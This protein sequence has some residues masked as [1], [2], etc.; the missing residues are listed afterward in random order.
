M[1]NNCG[2][3]G[4]LPKDKVERGDGVK[5]KIEQLAKGKFEYQLPP[6]LLSTEQI[7]I[8]A[9][10]GKPYYG[11]FTVSNKKKRRMK[12]VIYSDQILFEI[13]KELFVGEENEIRY[14]F[15]AEHLKV[16]ETLEGRLCIVTDAGEIWLP[17]KADVIQPCLHTSSKEVC[18]L[19]EFTSLAKDNWQEAEELFFGQQFADTLFYQDKTF[20]PLYRTLAATK[21]RGQALEQF[22]VAAG[23]KAPFDVMLETTEFQY[24]AMNYQFMDK[25]VFKKSGW[26]YA[27]YELS[28]DAEFLRLERKELTSSDF[29]DGYAYVGF[30]VQPIGLKPGV[31]YAHIK[32]SSFRGTM[33]AAVCCRV[34]HRLPEQWERRGRLR[35]AESYLTKNYLLFRS[36]QRD[37]KQYFAEA[38]RQLTV[39]RQEETAP[40][41]KLLA[42]LYQIHVWQASGR[43]LAAKNA[44]FYFDEPE[45][46]KL[47]EECPEAEGGLCYLYTLQKNP[48]VPYQE[49]VEKIRELYQ[50]HSDRWLLLWYLLYIDKKY[51]EK[52]TRLTVIRE[53]AAQERC[54]PVLMFEAL[55]AVREEPP[56]L[57]TLDS[58]SLQLLCFAVKYHY[59][60][61]GLLRQIIY[62]SMREKKMSPLLYHVLAGCYEQW[63]DKELLEVLCTLII[64]G[65]EKSTMY[66]RW[67]KLGV[68]EQIR[69]TE[70]PEYYMYCMDESSTEEIDPGIYMYFSH[71]SGLSNRKKALLYANLVRH[72][73]DSP[74]LYRK[75]QKEMEEFAAERM[76]AAEINTN[77][78]VIYNDIF[79]SGMP[80]NEG[81]RYLPQIAFTWRVSCEIECMTGVYVYHP[82]LLD[83]VTVPLV[84]G[85]SYVTLCTE[86]AEVFLIDSKGAYYPVRNFDGSS[87]RAG[88]ASYTGGKRLVKMEKLTDLDRCLWESY[89]AGGEDLS[90]LLC[91]A[92][93]TVRSHKHEEK[94]QELF[95][96]IAEQKEISH[97]LKKFYV[98]E[99]M[100][101]YYENYESELF[102]YY[103]GQVSLDELDVSRRVKVANLL[104][105]RG[106]DKQAFEAVV[107]F[108]VDG[109]DAKRLSKLVE[110]LLPEQKKKGKDRC[111]LW[112]AQYV[113]DC[114]K[115]EDNILEY[116]CKFYHG[117]T[118]NMYSVWKAAR[119]AELD[120]ESLEESLLGQILFAENCIENTQAVFSSYCRYGTNRKLIRAYLCYY[121]YKYLTNDWL[122]PV[123][124]FDAMES[125]LSVEDD[126]IC[127]IALL[128]HYSEETNLTERQEGFIAHKLQ[129]FIKRGL[130]LPFFRNFERLVKLPE[131]MYDKYFVEYHADPE[132]K[133]KIHYLIGEKENFQEAEMINAFLGIFVYGFV[134]F[135]DESLQYY[136]TEQS[137]SGEKLTQSK[138][139][140]LEDRFPDGHGSRYDNLNLV[141]TVHQMKE[142]TA[143]LDLLG[144]YI[145]MEYEAKH[146]F[147]IILD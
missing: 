14:I 106:F 147:R 86:G 44:L 125:E 84:N 87:E 85:S 139:V 69:I 37:A 1:C 113:F 108:G 70:L 64:R 59:I 4:W 2:M 134:L 56:L 49:A 95:Q 83:G 107:R 54:C 146:L 93:Q 16:G 57:R 121:A 99:L 115:Y 62:L 132:S 104:L 32:I 122:I 105:M 34:E 116:L 75:Y 74:E 138:S 55:A 73:Q 33:E 78:A 131:S 58:F 52:D 46:R 109:L 11:S 13:E 22:L 23:K 10:A 114:G 47:L 136:I 51:Q 29:V 36:G 92:E 28:C 126:D 68:R 119:N 31:H 130:F 82:E 102:E 91:L 141:L 98:Y 66:F 17:Y 80:D 123:G 30:V 140:M 12:G 43:E 20:E 101:Y 40:S 135:E 21:Q 60:N 88:V 45:A 26:G 42:R 137:D 24:S 39:F 41:A 77:L 143:V 38:E 120:T 89:E 94:K 50:K 112:L 133:V 15:H 79:V 63:S 9:E 118:E 35:Q 111:F 117:P 67:M 142:E 6:L 76:R 128:K 7:D 25:L 18:D 127:T 19:F 110:R 129:G 97:T 5:E 96:R 48:A 124:L 65:G 8:R 81:Y 100:E 61:D 145:R 3:T 90:L 103:L 71:S 27:R 53:F 144:A 72:K